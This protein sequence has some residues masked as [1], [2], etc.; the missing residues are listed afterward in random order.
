VFEGITHETQATLE[1]MYY[2]DLC[3]LNVGDMWDLFESL[4][5]SNGNVNVLVNLLCTL[6]NFPMIYTVN[7]H[8]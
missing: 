7:L 6:P 2:G 5:S 3:F 4:A 1:F 8:V